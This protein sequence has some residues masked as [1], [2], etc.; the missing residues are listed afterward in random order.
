MGPGEA[1]LAS[2]WANQQRNERA[3]RDA[4]AKLERAEAEAKQ[5]QLHKIEA[6]NQVPLLHGAS[7]FSM[8]YFDPFSLTSR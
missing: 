3:R 6:L 5:A 7:P 8:D 4:D 2:Q 1:P